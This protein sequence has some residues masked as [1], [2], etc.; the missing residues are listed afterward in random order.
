[1]GSIQE[2][3]TGDDSRTKKEEKKLEESVSGDGELFNDNFRASDVDKGASSK[4]REH[5]LDHFTCIV[6]QNH[7]NCY[8]KRGSY[9]EDEHEP[10]AELEVVGEGLHERDSERATGG[11]L[12]D[13]NG[14]RDVDRVFKF[15][16]ETE[17]ETFKDGV[18]G[19]GDHEDEGGHVWAARV[20]LVDNCSLARQW[21]LTHS[22]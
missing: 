3:Q 15:R 1:M 10:S 7:A 6:L 9:R 16:S 18:H 11:A 12:V 2:P 19:E 13:Q 22:R 21:L 4:A 14:D 20:R 5:N 17:S 8:S